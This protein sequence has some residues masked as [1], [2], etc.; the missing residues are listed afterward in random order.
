MKKRARD[1][2]DI[3]LETKIEKKTKPSNIKESIS[4]VVQIANNICEV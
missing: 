3:M 1:I 2:A 4:Q